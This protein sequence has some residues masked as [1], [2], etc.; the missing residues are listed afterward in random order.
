[1]TQ[2]TPISMRTFLKCFNAT[3]EDTLYAI[4]V[5]QQAIERWNNN[6]RN[7][8]I[9]ET[10]ASSVFIH[11]DWYASQ[12]S[13]ERYMPSQLSKKKYRDINTKELLSI[14]EVFRRNIDVIYGEPITIEI[15][16]ISK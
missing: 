1:M 11:L 15:A 7:K 3:E 8:E 6:G 12:L 16:Y 9:Q 10:Q 2:I 5:I 4:E 14:K 13:Y